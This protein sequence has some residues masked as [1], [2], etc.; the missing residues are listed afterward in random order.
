MI[1]PTYLH[2]LSIHLHEIAFQL[3]LD[4][5][6]LIVK[7]KMMLMWLHHH[8]LIFFE[9]FKPPLSFLLEDKSRLM[10]I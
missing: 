7:Y 8:S 5:Y 6:L 10:L 4:N 3:L 2:H 9:L 1:H